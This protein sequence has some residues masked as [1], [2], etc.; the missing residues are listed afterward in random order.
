MAFAAGSQFNIA[1]IEESTPGTTPGSP[2]MKVFRTT[3]TD[4]DGQKDTFQSNE[5]RSDQEIVDF[6]HGNRRNSGNLNFEFSYGAFDDWLKAIV[7]ASSWATVATKT[8]T[9]I[10]AVNSNPDTLTDSGSGFVTAGFE[11]GDEI[12][13][14][15]G[16]NNGIVITAATVAAGTI[17]CVGG[18]SLTAE[19]AG[20]SI[21]LTAA[22]QKVA[23]GTT[24]QFFTV[25]LRHTDVSVYRVFTGI[26]ANTVSMS[27]QPNAPVTGSIGVLGWDFA[28]N[29]SSLDASP[30]DVAENEVFTIDTGT[31]K[32]DGVS[33]AIVTGIDFTIN[34]GLS[35]AFVA[36]ATSAQQTFPGRINVTGTITMFLENRTYLELF[37]NETVFTLE[38]RVTDGTQYYDI[39]FPKLK[40]GG[41]PTPVQNEAGIVTSLPFQG[42]RDSTVGASIVIERSNFA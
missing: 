7:G 21:T 6:R 41:A 28:N 42:L 24:A 19:V 4:L 33:V 18:D 35:L 36:A 8:A 37:K 16:A 32:I 15:G 30:A 14:T 20:T 26:R 17:T 31:I 23:S 25:E 12:T 13:I 5:L 1:Y 3:G 29:T 22:R 2:S 39:L 34:R 9:T 38:V 11:A 27:I 10:A 40:P